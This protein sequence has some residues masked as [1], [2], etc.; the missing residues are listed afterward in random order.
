MAH[1]RIV[2][3]M[4][5]EAAAV[6][7]RDAEPNDKASARKYGRNRS[8]MW[9]WGHVG[10]GSPLY[11]AHQY[12][13]RCRDP[14]RAA[15]SLVATAKLAVVRTMADAELIERYWDLRRQEGERE[16]ADHTLQATAH[17]HRDYAEMAW[18]KERDGSVDLELS[19]VLRE[20][21]RRRLD[22]WA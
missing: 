7:H 18:A 8:T 2:D 16:G 21:A 12:L 22:P 9:R 6:A 11:A 5:A 14:W 3:D 1:S 17:Q 20:I 15:A 4:L 13:M 10:K 19:A